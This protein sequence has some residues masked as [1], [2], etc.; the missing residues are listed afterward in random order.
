V[1]KV[2]GSLAVESDALRGLCVELCRVA[3][4]FRVVVVPGG[5]EFADVVRDIDERFGLVRGLRIGWLL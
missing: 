5:G 2:G 3:E 4:R 1:I